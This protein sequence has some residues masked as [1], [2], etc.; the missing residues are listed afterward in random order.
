M[1]DPVSAKAFWLKY[2]LLARK[3]RD[4]TSY[5]EFAA[6]YLDMHPRTI[7]VAELDREF[8]EYNKF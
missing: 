4:G 1:K 7:D 5:L 6:R 2:Q 3:S 8:A